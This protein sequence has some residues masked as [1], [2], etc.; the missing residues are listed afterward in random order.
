MEEIRNPQRYTQEG[1]KMECWDFW[2][3]YG[4]NPFIASAVKY[5]WRYKAMTYPQYL[6]IANSV[7]TTEAESYL[8]GI[9]NMITLINKLIGDEYDIH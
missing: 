2:L 8:L 9:D 6:I 7:L 3:H 5:V 1:N 4:L